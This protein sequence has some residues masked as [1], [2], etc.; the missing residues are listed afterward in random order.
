MAEINPLLVVLF[1]FF[2]SCSNGY[3]EAEKNVQLNH[4]QIINTENDSVKNTS[5]NDNIKIL[6]DTCYFTVEKLSHHINTEQCEYHPCPL[7]N[8]DLIFSG[9]DRTGF[10]DFRIDFTKTREMGG[11]DIFISKKV[12]GIFTDARMMEG[13]NT[14]SHQVINQ[15]IHSEKFIGTGN[16]PENMSPPSSD[17]GMTTC[18]IFM[19]TN[20]KS[21]KRVIHLKEPVNSIFSEFDPYLVDEN[22]LLFVSDRPSSIGDYHK[23]GWKWNDS[24]WGNTNIYCS[25]R[26]GDFWSEPMLLPNSINTPFTERSP[27]L[28]KDGLTLF[29]SSNGY[30]N[31][32]AD[33]NIYYFKRTDKNNW[34]DWQGPYLLKDLNTDTDEW[35]LQEDNF[36]NYYFVRSYKLPY[37]SNVPGK[38]G[39]GGVRETNYRPGYDVS[40]C[41]SAALLSTEQ[42]DI[43]IAKK[44][45]LP[46]LILEDV[47]FEFNSDHINAKG[48][49]VLNRVV[50]YVNVNRFK[51]IQLLGYTDNTGD[52]KHNINLSKKRAER[53]ADFFKSK[54][55]GDCFFSIK[56]KGSTNP[57]GDNKTEAGRKKNRR[58]EIYFGATQ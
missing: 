38:N 40:G 46:S 20:L 33:L 41:A 30:E 16:Y 45:G 1:F 44:K 9:M 13:F 19:Y 24:F 50:D 36:G 4:S 11:E 32:H 27:F 31:N 48:T 17:A 25:T 39:D 18:D 15:A 51:S 58:V 54:G 26:N 7:P 14:N 21:E 8:G 28:S 55:L 42:S 5:M 37:K 2:I 43:L 56:G 6:F 3:K 12:Y 22:T 34:K 29:L 10:F 52:E 35:G 47:L 49:E 23:K 57:S 53:V